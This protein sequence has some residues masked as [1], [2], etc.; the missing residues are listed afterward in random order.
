MDASLLKHTL[1]G[2][3]NWVTVQ[4]VENLMDGMLAEE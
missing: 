1:K 2:D 3:Y 4:D